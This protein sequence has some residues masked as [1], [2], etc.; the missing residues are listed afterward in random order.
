MKDV[1]SK[2]SVNEAARHSPKKVYS[3]VKS[4]VAGN[5]RSITRANK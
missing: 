3:G 2:A 4:K 1:K 5:M